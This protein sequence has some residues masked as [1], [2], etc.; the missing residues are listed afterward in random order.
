MPMSHTMT[1]ALGS[2]GPEAG[3]KVKGATELGVR[4]SSTV[5]AAEWLRSLDTDGDGILSES[6]LREAAFFKNTLKNLK[7]VFDVIDHDHS[8]YLDRKEM[9]ECLKMMGKTGMQI[10]I[11]IKTYDVDNNQRITFSEFCTWFKHDIVGN[12]DPSLVITAMNRCGKEISSWS[13]WRAQKN[14]LMEKDRKELG[15]I[16][17]HMAM[18]KNRI[19]RL[20]KQQ[21]GLEKKL[22]QRDELKAQ[23]ADLTAKQT[24]FMNA[25]KAALPSA[26][27]LKATRLMN[28]APARPDYTKSARSR[29]R[30]PRGGRVQ[31]A[32]LLG[33]A[34]AATPRLPPPTKQKPPPPV[35]ANAKTKA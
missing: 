24:E 15:E 2:E 10:R 1:E 6:E 9:V 16:D 17:K 29:S 33:S 27:R 5:Q 32:P 12:I 11:W 19:Q 34:T 3:G 23:I 30:A 28:M 35:L 21:A 4:R 8:G 7:S 31:K 20:E 22:K 14:R 25:Q 13:T 26:A 18:I